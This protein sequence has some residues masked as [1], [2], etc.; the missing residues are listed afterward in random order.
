MVEALTELLHHLVK[1]G[2]AGMSEGRMSH[3]VNQRQGFGQV[4]VQTQHA[5]DGAR[6]LR[7]LDGVGEAVA[8]MIRESGRENLGFVFQP[9]ERAG[10]HDAIAIPLKRVPVGMLRLRITATER[11]PDREPQVR[12]HR[13]KTKRVTG[14]ADPA[15]PRPQP[16]RL[17]RR[18][19]PTATAACALPPAASKPDRGRG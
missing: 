11:R 16:G 10:M 5:G 2:F 3:V 6:Y 14:E 1:R 13:E 17:R 12:K 4:F 7:D 9:P 19:S 15:S 8:E 18:H